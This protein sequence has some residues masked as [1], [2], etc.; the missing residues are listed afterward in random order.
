MT[1]ECG[2][3]QG[4]VVLITGASSGIGAAAA[5]V[6][7]REG[8]KV[9]LAARREERLRELVAELRDKGA[10]AEY[11][12]ADMVRREDTRQAVA[13]AVE[14]F[15]RL[16]GAFN[17]AGWGQGRT[18]LHEMDDELYDQIMDV[19]VRGVWNCLRDE[20]AAM[21]ETGGGAIVNNSSVAA[22][23][24]TPVAAPY[25]A[26]KHAVVGLTK[27][28]AAEYA[29]AGIRVNSV[30][31][32]TTRTEV[33]SEWFDNNPGIEEMLHQ[34]TPQPRTAEPEEIAEAAAWLLSDRASFVTGQT[35]PVDGG[36][37]VV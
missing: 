13:V 28:A 21:L 20:I 32:G 35:V 3:L 7:A 14:T 26:S 29:A 22:L 30:A 33:V 24:A 15:G 27:A 1:V 31:P 9:V 19:N 36:F 8:A 18:P 12:V 17:N 2:I 25:V 10:E 37:T 34:A 16:D 5:R 23:L 6:F 4:K 11:V